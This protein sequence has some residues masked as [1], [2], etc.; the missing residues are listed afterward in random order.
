MHLL[1]SQLLDPSMFRSVSPQLKHNDT[2]KCKY[3]KYAL[4]DCKNKCA[5]TDT[6]FFPISQATPIWQ[7]CLQLCPSSSFILPN[8]PIPETNQFMSWPSVSAH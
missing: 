5:K 8:D 4:W 1:H 6:G 7:P 3:D 2:S